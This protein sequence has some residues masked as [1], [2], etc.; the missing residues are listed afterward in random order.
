[1][2]DV[3]IV[4]PIGAALRVFLS[5]QPRFEALRQA[6][7]KSKQVRWECER[8]GYDPE[9]DSA[10]AADVAKVEKQVVR[11]AAAAAGADPAPTVTRPR[12][13]WQTTK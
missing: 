11:P 9:T 7:A 5:A 8:E 4:R 2:A 1:M 10:A 13:T 12:R 6:R 3:G